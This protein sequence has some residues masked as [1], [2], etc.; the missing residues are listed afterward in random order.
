MNNSRR[1]TLEWRLQTVVC[2]ISLAVLSASAAD[3]LPVCGDL[4][5]S[6]DPIIGAITDGEDRTYGG[7]GLGKTFPGAATPFGMVQL[8]P[9]TVTGG[10]NGPGYSYSH[11]TIE[12][13]SF[14]HMSG[15]GWYGDL[16]NIQFMPTVGPRILDRE[17]A[18]SP[19]SH[20]SE[21]AR[22]GRYA[23]RL[24]RYGITAELAAAPHSGIMRFTYPE[25]MTRR[26]QV[27]LGRRIGQNGRWL[28]HSRQNMRTL[29]DRTVIGTIRCD[30]RDG[31]FG[32][33][34]GQVNYRLSFKAVFSEPFAAFGAWERTEALPSCMEYSGTNA[35][36]Y[37]EFAPGKRPL[38]VRVGISFTDEEGASRNLAAEI[39]DSASFDDVVK[40]AHGLWKDAFAAVNVE[41]G[42]VSERIVF[43]TALYHAFL[44]PRTISDVDGRRRRAD[45]S[46]AEAQN[47]TLRTIF[48]GWDVFRSEFPLLGIIRP[49]IVRDT[50]CSMSDVVSCGARDTLPVWDLF[51]CRSNCMLG[52]PILPVMAEA[53][54]SGISGWNEKVLWEQAEVTSAKRGN[55]PYGWSP[56]SLSETLEYAFD[57]ACM[58]KI[59]AHMGHAD[60]VRHYSERAKWYRNVWSEEVGWMRSRMADGSWMPW[61]GKERHGQGTVECNPYQQCWFVPHDVYGL[62]ELMGGEERFAKELETFFDK[63]PDDFL[64]GDY[65]NHPNEPC[66]HIAF[67]FPYCGKPWLTQKWTRRIC[68]RAYG[69]GPK[70][71]CGNEDVGQ[72]SAWYVLSALGLHPVAP[73]SGVWILTSPIFAK[74]SVR[75]ASG[76][77]FT[78]VA[79]GNSP[80]NVY[81]Q[82]ATLNG[83]PLDRAWIT[84][85]EILSGATLSFAMG[86]Q[87]AKKLFTRLPPNF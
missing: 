8:S 32:H 16:G 22:P 44:D 48:S 56:G 10:D 31:G 11:K 15:I 6:V 46:I 34:K 14:T 7:H 9:D 75:L 73:G 82:D 5:D 35:G 37:A 84:T 39:P 64:W 58:A 74:A 42:S 62:M 47:F 57:D 13:F 80:E 49:D 59:A 3:T 23:V 60:R 27:D 65:Y 12:G 1:M 29:D 20:D 54:A 45:G 36:F 21:T 70:G 30:S 55:A 77:T 24:D 86:P 51:G 43:A 26:V 53:Y 85:E 38:E 61:K 50:I 40:R 4:V 69:T 17:K 2:V 68:E 28:V 63:A 41:G 76:R 79:K 52:N 67:L 25:G 81:I 19:F 33:G 18:V 66:H 71:L 78:V 87:P 72:M 83:R